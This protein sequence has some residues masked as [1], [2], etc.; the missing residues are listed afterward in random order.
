MDEVKEHNRTMPVAYCDYQEAYDRVHYD[1]TLKVCIWMG[2]PDDECR[3]I[4]ELMK[5]WK[6][7]LKVWKDGQK[8]TSRWISIKK[9]FLEGD[10]YSPI[11]V[12]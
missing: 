2:I 8:E 11:W 5:K 3:L 1:W 9:G 4:E 7:R 12:R 6:T 10:S